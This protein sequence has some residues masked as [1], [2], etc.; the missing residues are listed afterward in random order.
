MKLLPNLRT[1]DGQPVDGRGKNV[2]EICPPQVSEVKA[3]NK[4]ESLFVD[5]SSKSKKRKTL[6]GSPDSGSKPFIDLISDSQQSGFSFS[7][8][9]MDAIVSETLQDPIVE[10]KRPSGKRSQVGQRP[11]T[12]VTEALAVSEIGMGGSSTWDTGF[13]EVTESSNSGLNRS[14]SS[15]SGLNRSAQPVYSRWNFKVSQG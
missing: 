11:S 12:K 7:A 3:Q 9:G 10:R 8:D 5:A 1:L 6:H 13:S 4:A 2:K 14:E 15:H